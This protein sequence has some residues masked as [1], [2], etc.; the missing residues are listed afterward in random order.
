MNNFRERNVLIKIFKKASQGTISLEEL[1]R[2]WKLLSKSSLIDLFYEDI[3]D[4]VVHLPT[5]SFFSKE[6]KLEYWRE[7]RE[8]KILAAELIL[9]EHCLDL[10]QC[11]RIREAILPRIFDFDEQL[12]LKLISEEK[13][14]Q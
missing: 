1:N 13:R 8:Y 14:R 6:L 2:E 9:L 11:F 4:A 12:I 5:K 7:Q 10:S 3:Q